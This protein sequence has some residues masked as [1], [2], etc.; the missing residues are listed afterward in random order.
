[1]VLQKESLRITPYESS[2]QHKGLNVR[3]GSLGFN[4]WNTPGIVHLQCAA[5]KRVVCLHGGHDLFNAT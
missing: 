1:M 3:L 2:N 5:C 4:S